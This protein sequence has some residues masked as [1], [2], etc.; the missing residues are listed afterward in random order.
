MTSDTA[1]AAT[2]DPAPW[3]VPLE[4]P[5]LVSLPDV[6]PAGPDDLI[7]WLWM[8]LG[9][10][11]LLAIDEGTVDV[12]VAVATGLAPGPLVIDTAAAPR[13]RDW[14]AEQSTR[15]I[16][17]VFVDEPAARAALELLTPIAGLS[18]GPP[19]AA[20]AVPPVVQEPVAVPGFGWVLPPGAGMGRPHGG[21][22][23]EAIA[24]VIIDAGTGFGTGLHPTTRLCLQALAR[25]AA[26][27]GRL[28]RILDVGAGSGILGLA[29]ALCGGGHVD[30]VE[31]DPHVHGAIVHNAT[32][33]GVAAR[34]RL[35]TA[36]A[37]L[38]PLP[39][40]A[41]RPATATYDLVFANIVAPVLM[42]LAAA[43]CPLVARPS[44]TLILSGLRGEDVA[45][46]AACYEQLVGSPPT[47]HDAEGWHCLVV[48]T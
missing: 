28:D 46:V 25:H 18:I 6:G 12:A 7:E 29:A 10:E 35:A 5:A 19:R 11:G 41:A 22:G 43:L 15:R 9:E 39:D 32:L 37:E 36:L 3:V 4:V 34:V 8:R 44:G 42:E 17:L 24:R 2:A 30:A 47:I 31:I 13:Q 21:Q 20:P 1:N 48:R 16:E 23:A 45:T 38:A 40:G 26:D 27:G 14:V 33:N